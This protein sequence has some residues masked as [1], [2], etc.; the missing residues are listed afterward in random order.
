[1]ID[2]RWYPLGK[3]MIKALPLETNPY[4]TTHHIY[5]R[6]K[7]IG[8]QLSVP[9]VSD[10]EWYAAGAIYAPSE[11]Y[12]A[13]FHAHRKPGPGRP[14]KSSFK[15]SLAYRQFLGTVPE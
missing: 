15:P 6:G 2:R 13:N 9:C 7:L 4:W 8:R 12:R 5:L 11:P 10:C 1:M 14:R 3:F